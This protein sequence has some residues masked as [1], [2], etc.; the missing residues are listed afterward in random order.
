MTQP[1]NG[2]FGPFIFTRWF[3]SPDA[4]KS[5]L[6]WFNGRGIPAGIVKAPGIKYK[7]SGMERSDKFALWRVGVDAVEYGTK[8]V[9]LPGMEVVI[10][11]NG[12]DGQF[13]KYLEGVADVRRAADEREA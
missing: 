10:S 13:N 7:T 12:F 8:P 1:H 2:K 5:W 4:V 9:I 11:V 6:G 3:T